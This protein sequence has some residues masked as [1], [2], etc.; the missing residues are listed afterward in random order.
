[1]TITAG[2][3]GEEQQQRVSQ[4]F[5]TSLLLTEEEQQEEESLYAESV[6]NWMTL[7]SCWCRVVALRKVVSHSVPLSSTSTSPLHH[8]CTMHRMS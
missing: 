4:L 1:M 5:D 6:N 8:H 3:C 2:Y 7:T